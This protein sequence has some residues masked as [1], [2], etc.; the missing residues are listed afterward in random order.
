[1]CVFELCKWTTLPCSIESLRKLLLRARAQEI[2]WEPKLPM[3]N[4]ESNRMD[5]LCAKQYPAIAKDIL[6]VLSIFLEHISTDNLCNQ[7]FYNLPCA[8]TFQNNVAYYKT[9]RDIARRQWALRCQYQFTLVGIVIWFGWGRS[10][11]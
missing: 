4:I 5:P 7:F 11:I 6:S 9:I 10:H 3:A 1:M 2:E 8:F